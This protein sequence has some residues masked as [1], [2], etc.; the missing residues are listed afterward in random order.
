MSNKI[1]FYFS[2][3]S[4]YTVAH[5]NYEDKEL[6]RIYTSEDSFAPLN[7]IDI[8]K[9]NTH[10]NFQF[11][12]YIP[13]VLFVDENIAVFERPPSTKLLS[14]TPALLDEIKEDTPQYDYQ[15]PIPWQVYVVVFNYDPV[16][17]RHNISDVYMFFRDSP[18]SSF[19]DQVYSAPLPNFYS[20]GLLC[21]PFYNTIQDM[22]IPEENT[23]NSLLFQAYNWI[24]N[25]DNNSDLTATV[26]DYFNFIKH[27][28][29]S[30]FIR[31][32]KSLI[33]PLSYYCTSGNVKNLLD[34]WQDLNFDDIISISWCPPSSHK[35]YKDAI[36]DHLSN[37]LF[38]YARANGY[39]EY[40]EDL[41]YVDFDDLQES[42]NISEYINTYRDSIYSPVTLRTIVDSVLESNYSEFFSS[43]TFDTDFVK[44]THTL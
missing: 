3:T 8:L 35:F 21:R 12:P 5:Q 34:S 14:Y 20:N 13:G 11:E 22:N 9:N 27:F 37:N 40:C 31:S 30:H 44:F 28:E 6:S 24:W 7:Y 15:I 36:D 18:L 23:L 2:D 32:E 39:L 1:D 19:D 33:S 41:D 29:P 25:S 17:L 26:A 16:F 4:C 42:I 43:K 10:G 38:E